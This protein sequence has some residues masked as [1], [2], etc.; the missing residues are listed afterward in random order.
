ML[1]SAD[2]RRRLAGQA[3]QR[4]EEFSSGRMTAR[5]ARVYEG[6]VRR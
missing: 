3:R 6:L 5:L 2:L 1:E 4:A